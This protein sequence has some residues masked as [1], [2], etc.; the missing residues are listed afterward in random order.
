MHCGQV[1]GGA[2][3]TVF[4]RWLLAGMR[5]GKGATDGLIS[6]ADRSSRTP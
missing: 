2:L 1:I 5:G 3:A 4:S 6:T